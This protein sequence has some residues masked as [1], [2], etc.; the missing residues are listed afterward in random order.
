MNQVVILLKESVRVV[1]PIL[2]ST[3]TKKAVKKTSIVVLKKI[4]MKSCKTTNLIV[5]AICAA[6]ASVVS[7][8]T[9]DY[10]ETRI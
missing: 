4:G 10:L 2:I 1:T 3:V 7:S 8:L 9:N 6:L 5:I